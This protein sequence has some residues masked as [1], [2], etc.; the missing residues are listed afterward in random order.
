MLYLLGFTIL[1]KMSK[2]KEEKKTGE[3]K[4]YYHNEMC[5]WTRDSFSSEVEISNE[6]NW[7]KITRLTR[8]HSVSS[9]MSFKSHLNAKSFNMV[10]SI[11]LSSIFGKRETCLNHAKSLLIVN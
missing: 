1:L 2:I 4:H 8:P 6:F 10:L 5:T 9:N 3:K 7:G 11:M